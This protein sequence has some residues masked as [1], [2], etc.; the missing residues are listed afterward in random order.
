[1]TCENVQNLLILYL[2]GELN[3]FDQRAVQIHLATCRD[4]Q[5]ELAALTAARTSVG[6]ALQSLVADAQPSSQAWSRLQ[7]RLA[8]EARPSPSKLALWLAHLAPG[9][10]HWRLPILQGDNKMRKILLTGVTAF[11]FLAGI[12][13]FMANNVITVSAQQILDRAAAVQLSAKP[14]Q[15]IW[16]FRIEN[17]ENPQVL[18]GDQAGTKTTIDIYDGLSAGSSDTTSAGPAPAGLYRTVTTEAAGKVIDAYANDGSFSYSTNGLVSTTASQLTIYRTPNGDNKKLGGQ[19]DD[20]TS[21]AKALFDEFRNN[22]RVKLEGKIARTNGKQAYVLVDENYQTQKQA[23]GPDVKTYIG[24]TKMVFDVETYALLES[25]TTLQKDGKDIVIESFEF[26]VNETLPLGSQVAWNLSDL[27]GAVIV[28]QPKAQEQD[29]SSLQFKVISEQELAKHAK[30]YVLKTIPAG[31]TQKIIESPDQTP[32]E[33]YKYEVNYHSQA[34]ESFD[35]MGVG[36]LTAGFVEK[37][38]YDG[39]YKTASG[40]VL[41]YGT[42]TN[43]TTAMLSLPDGTN[44]LLGSSLPRE[45]VQAL[46]ED[47]VPVQ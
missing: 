10:G 33:P 29:S 27:K 30:A 3:P 21:M 45:R 9:G 7:V 32:G 1:M 11:V 36:Y 12:V 18:A 31:F 4:C 13:I 42:S 16:H 19:R 8:E 46:V 25:Q 22:P 40:L 35:M 37:S 28:D 39:S 14:V 15:G 26:L 2:D 38:F 47:L 23:N 41:H 5:T 44:V 43:S 24:S 20:P 17:Y 6:Q 34:N